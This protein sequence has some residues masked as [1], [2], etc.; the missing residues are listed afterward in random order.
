MNWLLSIVFWLTSPTACSRQKSKT[1]YFLRQFGSADLLAGLP[2]PARPRCFVSS[3]SSGSSASSASTAS[4][5][6]RSLIRDRAGGALLTLAPDGDPG[7][8]IR[9]PRDPSPRTVPDRREHHV[10]IRH[11]VVRHRHDLHRQ[12]GDQL[13]LSTTIGRLPRHTDH[14]HRRRHL[15]HVHRLSG[16]LVPRTV[17]EAD[18]PQPPPRQATTH[19]PRSISSKS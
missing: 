13:S 2:L 19:G 15:R 10:G 4:K 5:I 18:E 16:E 8:R 14:R 9:R 7:A 3:V 17:E 6:A 11:L 1:G 12:Y